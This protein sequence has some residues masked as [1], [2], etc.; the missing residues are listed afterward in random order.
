[1]KI[2]LAS[3]SAYRRS[4]L[5]RI[6]DTFECASPDID[7]QAQPDESP[8]NLARRL[9]ETKAK[10]LQVRYP[11][12]LII[13]SDQVAWLNGEQLHKPGNR[14]NNIDQLMR[15]Q[16]KTLQF[17]TGLAVLNSATGKL[18][19]CVE[20]YQTRFRHRSLNEIERYVDREQAFD[21]AGGFKMEGLGICLFESIE[22]KDPNTLIGLPLIRLVSMLE[23]EGVQIL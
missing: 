14:A 11:D 21:C 1:M 9:A 8:E 19:S 3:S 20:L 12:A 4:L 23:Q 6:L 17:Y 16:G 13:G 22:G 10:A 18:H 5:Q 7:E 15:S 2:I